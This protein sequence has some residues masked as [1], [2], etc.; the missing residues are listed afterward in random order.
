MG[1]SVC[2]AHWREGCKASCLS[3]SSAIAEGPQVRYPLLQTTPKCTMVV[4]PL[5]HQRREGPVGAR[6][7]LCNP[8]VRCS[9]RCR[10]WWQ[11]SLSRRGHHCGH[12]RGGLGSPR[13]QPR[14]GLRRGRGGGHRD[15][16]RHL[17]HDRSHTAQLQSRGSRSALCGCAQ[18]IS[19]LRGSV[20]PSV[21]CPEQNQPSVGF[22][23]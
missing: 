21:K 22:E 8:V 3:Q 13:M 10:S 7:G 2:E 23:D 18:V 12:P 6:R 19:R 9:R 14:H 1:C 16:H 11:P 17:S 20:S 15:G 5:P 4:I